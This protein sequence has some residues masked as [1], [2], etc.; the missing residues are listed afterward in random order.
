MTAKLPPMSED[1]LQASVVE[2]ARRLGGLVY[3]T[4]D[5]RR[6]PARFPDL[7]IAFPRTGA[8]IFA[9]LKSTRGRLRPDQ[10][11]WLDALRAGARQTYREVHLWTPRDWP[12]PIAATLQRCTRVVLP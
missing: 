3:H 1:D 12:N 9:E 4:H 10:A 8:L 11:L 7:V 6:S 2:L 5:S